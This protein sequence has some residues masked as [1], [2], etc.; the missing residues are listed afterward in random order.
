MLTIANYLI[1]LVT[2]LRYVQWT[3]DSCCISV[4]TSPKLSFIPKFVARTV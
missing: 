2:N 4:S 1:E 3:K